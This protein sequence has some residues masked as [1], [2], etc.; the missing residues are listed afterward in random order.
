MKTLLLV[1]FTAI[2]LVYCSKQSIRIT[3]KLECR[4]KPAQFVELQLLAW[5]NILGSAILAENVFTDADGY[6]DISGYAD[7][8][9]TI[10]GRLW[11]WH[12]C[13]FDASV[14]KDPCKNWLEFKVPDDFVSQGAIPLLTW[15]LGFVDL[16]KEQRNEHL[17]KCQ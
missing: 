7:Q 5:G 8:Y 9:F 15:P 14:Q 16:E 13:F 17:D 11:I 4:G 3:G 6:F 12:T 10:S 2:P 1:I